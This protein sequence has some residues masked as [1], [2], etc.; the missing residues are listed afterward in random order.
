MGSHSQ[1][2]TSKLLELI[3][4]SKPKNDEI[5]DTL[6][7]IWKEFAWYLKEVAKRHDEQIDTNREKMFTLD[8]KVDLLSQDFEHWKAG[9]DTRM[10]MS[11]QQKVIAF[12]AFII[13]TAIAI[14][15]LLR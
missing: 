3:K 7:G 14:I 11:L 6:I 13:P 12:L 4:S 2:P 9:A 15:S 10:N 1:A 8:R 5:E